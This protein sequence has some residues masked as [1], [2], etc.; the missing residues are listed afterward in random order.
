MPIRICRLLTCGLATVSLWFGAGCAPVTPVRSDATAELATPETSLAEADAALERGD[1]P[2]AARAYRLAAQGSDDETVAEQATRVAFE[3]QQLQETA[4]AAARWLELNP[5]S[6]E[7]HRYA[8][9]AALKLHRL[10]EAERQ[11]ASLLETAY[12][13]PA[14]GF[15]AL[16]PALNGEAVP[17]DVMELFRRLSARFPD[18]AEGHYALG[19]AALRADNFKLAEQSAET[20]VAKAPFWKPAKMLLARTRVARGDEE[21]GL[22]LARELVTEPDS[23]VA[24]HLEYALMLAATGR[25]EEARA[26]LTPYVSGKTVI[27]GAVRTVGVMDLDAGN[28]DA[29]TTQF[30]NLLS[31]GAQSYEALYFLGVIAERREDP[32]RAVR[33]YQRVASGDYSLPAQ[34]RVARIKAE[35]SGVQA[36]LAH[37]DEVARSMPQLAPDIYAAKAA[38]LE[39]KGEPRRA[40]QT[41]DEAIARYP[42]SLELRMSRVFFLERTG[43]RDA[44]VR[45]LRDLL[46]QRPGDAHLQNAL[47][48]TLADADRDLAEARTLITAALEQSPDNAAMLDSM[49]WL[50]H[51]EGR[52]AEALEVLRRSAE[53]GSD[54]EID[55]HIGEVQWALGDQAA[56]RDTWRKALERAP[57]NEDL[58]RRLERAGP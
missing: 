55:L 4:L 8:G 48:Y 37:L 51:R 13:S 57:D 11:F 44:A 15:L 2:A 5:T 9:L 10:D 36:G 20:A 33:Y 34:Q 52:N 38:L 54:P 41:F 17:A 39:S 7:A 40:L 12:I 35:Q 21:G 32:E 6:E 46:Q 30:E 56:A 45:E 43:K 24:T 22:A 23:D 26:M 29:A 53:L 19:S 47:G 27:P 1:L 42:D 31:T 16:A 25:D 49:G 50:L 3:H 18:V 28:L 58:Q 14:A